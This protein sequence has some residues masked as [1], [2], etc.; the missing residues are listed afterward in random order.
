[1]DS[2][3]TDPSA[4]GRP[5][6]KA[7][8]GVY[9]TKQLFFEMTTP[10]DRQNALYSLKDEDHESNGVKY[11]SMRRLF[12]AEQDP[13]GYLVSLKYFGGWPHWTRL[14]KCSW[15][16]D[17]LSLWQEELDM[18]MA[19]TQLRTLLDRQSD[20]K[21]AQYLLN[22][23]FLKKDNKVGR[24]TKEAIKLEAE[25]ISSDHQ[26]ISEDLYRIESLVS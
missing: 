6:F 16:M 24:P 20:P 12:L 10:Q 13:T 26:D 23:G 19:A 3:R 8:N 25:R 11:P 7:D 9:L 17:F 21:I 15:F 14:L 22:N 18:Q 4:T 1:M 2:S 5:K